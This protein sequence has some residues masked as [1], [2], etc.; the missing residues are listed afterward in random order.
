MLKQKQVLSSPLFRIFLLAIAVRLVFVWLY[1]GSAYYSGITG[2]YLDAAKNLLSG[3]GLSA[4]VDVAPF[5]SGATHFTYLPFIGRPIGY[6]LYFVVIA[7]FVGMQPIAFQIGQA[8]ITSCSVFLVAALVRESFGPSDRTE[9]IVKWAAILAAVWPNQARFEIALL[10]DGIV[11]L[12]MLAIP[13]LLIKYI[14]SRNSKYLFYAALTLGASIFFRPDLVLLPPF[15][16][17]ALLLILPWKETLKIAVLLGVVLA[18]AVGINTWKNYAISGEIVPLNLGSGTT[19]YEGISQFGDTLGTTYADERVSH[20]VFDTKQLFY[21]NGKTNDQKLFV[22]AVDTIKHHP[23]FYATVVLRRIPLMFTVRGLF[24][25]D[26]VS[27]SK[28]SDD[29]SQRFPGRYIAM[30]KEKP[31]EFVVRMLSPLLGWLLLTCGGI[32]LLLAMRG[33]AKAHQLLAIFL[34]YYIATHL[35]TNVEPRYF[36]PAVPLLYGYAI[37]LLQRRGAPA[38]SKANIVQLRR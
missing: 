10:P 37:F 26:S 18:I 22:I 30:F 4:Y 25:S 28:P 13:L 38:Q 35:M 3:H 31:I 32:G 36:Y 17:V 7:L 9:R 2:E 19:M 14:H 8:I 27:F 23:W 5:S 21:P 24:F 1:P 33:D 11:T 20:N 34:F 29:L 12:I 15:L 6:V 16:L